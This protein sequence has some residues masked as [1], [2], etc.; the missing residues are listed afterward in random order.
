M[1]ENE[2]E[3]LRNCLEKIK[4]C[5]VCNS[6]SFTM[7]RTEFD[8][9]KLTCF[10]SCLKCKYNKL[11]NFVKEQYDIKLAAYNHDDGLSAINLERFRD[12]LRDISRD[13]LKEI[14]ELT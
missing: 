1:T 7:D 10:F 14:D 5:S 12:I 4:N 8:G 13:I 3:S 2:K 11:L 9:I 6:S